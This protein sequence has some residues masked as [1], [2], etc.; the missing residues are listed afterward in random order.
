MIK[1]TLECKVIDLEAFVG[2]SVAGYNGCVADEGVVDTRVRDQVGLELVEID[3]QSTVEAQARCDGADNLSDKAV[4]MF[5]TGSG[6][7]Q[8]TVA[9]VVDSFVVNEEGAVRVF[10]GAM[11]GENG[12][13]RLDN[14]GGDTRSRVDCEFKLGLFAIIRGQTLQEESTET[15][16]GAAAKGVEDQKSLEGRAVVYCKSFL[17]SGLFKQE[18]ICI[19]SMHI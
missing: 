4:E 19:T 12:V 8:V 18:S 14:S 16:T 7:I 5:I 11:G 1:F 10:D 3:I 17:A 2:A 6:D 13:I 9:D 15:G